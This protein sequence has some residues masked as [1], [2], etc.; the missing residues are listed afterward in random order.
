MLPEVS[1]N[2]N[3]ALWTGEAEFEMNTKFLRHDKNDG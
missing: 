1:V 2:C 3:S